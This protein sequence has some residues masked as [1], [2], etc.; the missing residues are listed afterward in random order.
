ML[1]ARLSVAA[2]RGP[3]PIWPRSGP[4][5][6]ASPQ[7]T[8]PEA[9]PVPSIKHPFPA[10]HPNDP[11]SGLRAGRARLIDLPK[12]ADPRTHPTQPADPSDAARDAVARTS[13]GCQVASSG[14]L[15]AERCSI[16]AEPRS[17]TRRGHLHSTPQEPRLKEHLA[18]LRRICAT[19]DGATDELGAPHHCLL[20]GRGWRGWRGWG[21]RQTTRSGFTCT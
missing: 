9:T 18:R 15:E 11:R 16:Y 20:A 1:P 7:H 6:A 19:D 17:N 2:S 12:R 4:L 10:E 21:G 8:A 3:E 14:A 13:G 5:E